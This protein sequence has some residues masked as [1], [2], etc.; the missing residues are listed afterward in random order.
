MLPSRPRLAERSMCSSCAT[1]LCMTATRVSCGVTLMRMSSFMRPF[2]RMA[3]ERPGGSGRRADAEAAQQ[4][5]GSVQRLAHHA[6]IAAADLGHERAGAALD[7]V[8]AGLVHRF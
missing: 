6:R 5:R 8:G 3:Q 2:Y 4:Q 1:P 7:A